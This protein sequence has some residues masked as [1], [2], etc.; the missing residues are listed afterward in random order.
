MPGQPNWIPQNGLPQVTVSGTTVTQDFSLTPAAGISAPSNSFSRFQPAIVDTLTP[1]F[2]WPVYTDATDYII[3][4]ND[5]EG[6][7]LWG[8]FSADYTTR[9]IV[10]DKDTTSIDYNGTTPLED[11]KMYR[12]RLY[13]SK[14]DNG[15]GYDPADLVSASEEQLGLFKIVLAP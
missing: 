4:L 1:A 5:L 10:I 8:G 13:V 7:L 3:E 6:N 15:N 2:T 9:N 11:G 14:D 12:W